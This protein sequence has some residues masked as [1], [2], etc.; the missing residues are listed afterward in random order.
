MSKQGYVSIH[1]SLQEH[2]LWNEKPFDKKSA[3]IDLLLMVNYKD[4]KIMFDNELIEIRRGERITSI[5]K[6][7]DRWGWSNTKVRN[8][9][10]VLEK[11]NMISLKIA[12][13]KATVISIVNYNKFQ[14]TNTTKNTTETSQKH[15]RNTTETSQK[16]INN[17]ENKE[18]NNNNKYPE[19]VQRKFDEL[20][21]DRGRAT[22][23]D[24]DLIYLFGEEYF[25]LETKYNYNNGN[26]F[27]FKNEGHDLMQDY[28]DFWGDD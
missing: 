14:D 22:M 4:N 23:S 28:Y 3:W 7:C 5:K 6:L 21:K 2:W 12:P 1:R 9:L 20:R 17:K 19:S 18:N 27:K 16:H 25:G 26:D 15:Y 8:F 13:Q 10:K 24:E 11:D